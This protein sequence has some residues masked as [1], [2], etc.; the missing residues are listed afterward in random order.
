MQTVRVTEP[1][2]LALDIGGT[3][4]AAA[5][6]GSDGRLTRRHEVSAPKAPPGEPEVFWSAVQR[7]L[8]AVLEGRSPA[9]I[10]VGCGGPLRLDRGEV[11]PVNIPAWRSFPLVER[12]ESAYPGTP[13]RLHNDAVT[14]ALGEY[15]RGAGKGARSF[16]GV[17]V[18]TG[19]GAG[20]VI[21]GR[22]VSGPTGNA[23]HLGHVV[24]DPSGPAC[25]CGGIGCLEAVGRGPATVDWAI[26]EG[27]VPPDEGADGRALVASARAGDAVARR[28]LERAGHALGIALAGA[29]SLFE[30]ER[31]A[32]GGGFALGAGDL[33][34][35]P[36]R[37]ALARHACMD[38]AAACEIVPAALGND[39][40]LVGAAALITH[41]PESARA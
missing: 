1:A 40:G 11:S 23:G 33:L 7:L 5:L 37:D 19:V 31:V 16:L 25:G 20:V 18:S 28:A 24:V 30:L 3:K 35:D 27:W 17:V 15:L 26:R 29:T 12:L 36:A 13:V 2:V 10:G 8:E 4:I 32:V 9:A 39:A 41:R 34:L 14:M 38:F 22:L 21:D 6:V